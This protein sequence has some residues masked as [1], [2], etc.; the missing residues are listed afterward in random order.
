MQWNSKLQGLRHGKQFLAQPTTMMPEE[1]EVDCNGEAGGTAKKDECGEC[2][3]T[4]IK[5]W[6]CDCDHNV[7]DKN[8]VCPTVG[9]TLKVPD[10]LKLVKQGG[11][12]GGGGGPPDSGPS[13]P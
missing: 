12:G 7:K 8:G 1:L 13:R 2:G 6:E 5:S 10:R 4:G 9:N 3:G 11:R